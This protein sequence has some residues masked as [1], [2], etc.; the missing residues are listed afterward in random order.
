MSILLEAL[1]KSEKSQQR[2]EVPSIHE[3]NQ[4]ISS[5]ESLQTGPLALLLVAALFLSGW[6]VWRQYQA[7]P[8]SYQPP[9]TLKTDQVRTVATPK[10]GAAENS[11]AVSSIPAAET[12]VGRERTP[13]ESYEPGSEADSTQKPLN[14]AISKRQRNTAQPAN[15]NS[16]QSISKKKV[17]KTPAA[18]A[19]QKRRSQKPAPINYWELPDAIR[20]DVP[21]IRFSV[22]VYAKTPADRFVLIN[23]QRLGEGDSSQPGLEVQEIRRDGVIFSYRKYQFLVEK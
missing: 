6:F 1:R 4:S 18:V 5:S 8:G 14:S 9:V 23:G 7:P 20:A 19:P 17:S 16:S 21:E 10:A 11:Q 2:H 15:E 3:D 13:V 12:S 22:L